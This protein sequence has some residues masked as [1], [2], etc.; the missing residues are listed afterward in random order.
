MILNYET[1]KMHCSFISEDRKNTRWRKAD[2]GN[3]G[4]F[5]KSPTGRSRCELEQHSPP[6]GLPIRAP[7][8]GLSAIETGANKGLVPL[9][10]H[11]KAP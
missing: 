3:E 11:A 4:V 6:Q 2:I 1:A 7:G 9:V 5:E 8:I 10:D